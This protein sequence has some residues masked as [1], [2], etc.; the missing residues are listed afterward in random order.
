V[1][2]LLV[3]FVPVHCPFTSAAHSLEITIAVISRALHVGEKSLMCSL[4]HASMRPSPGGISVQKALISTAQGRGRGSAMAVVPATNIKAM[5]SG[6][7]D[8][9][10]ILYSPSDLQPVHGAK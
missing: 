6:V 10:D 2:S 9:L 8:F 3:R 7:I 4:I 5:P 1:T